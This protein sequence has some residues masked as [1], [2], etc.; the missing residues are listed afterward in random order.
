MQ[1]GLEDV[2]AASTRPSHVDGEG[3]QLVSTNPFLWPPNH[4]MVDV[5]IAYTAADNCGPVSTELTIASSES[6]RADSNDRPRPDREV[7][8]AHHVRL[9]AEHDAHRDHV[10]RIT[11]TATDGAGNHSAASIAVRVPAH[12]R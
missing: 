4:R 8:D 11:V 7:I 5:T 6:E 1:E 3:G 12:P 2:V 9:E 10:Y